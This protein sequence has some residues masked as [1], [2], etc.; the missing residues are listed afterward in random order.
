MTFTTRTLTPKTAPGMLCVC[1]WCRK[2]RSDEGAWE[3]SEKQIH[4]RERAGAVVTHGICPECVR[5]LRAA[6]QP[7]KVIKRT[8]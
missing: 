8:G 6:R 7:G 5:K 4:A 1:A 2:M 3:E